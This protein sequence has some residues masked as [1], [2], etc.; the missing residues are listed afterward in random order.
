M[1]LKNKSNIAV[2]GTYEFVDSLFN[3][4]YSIEICV[5]NR[6]NSKKRYPYEILWKEAKLGNYSNLIPTE[7]TDLPYPISEND[8]FIFSQTERFFLK[9]ADRLGYLESY[10]WRKNLYLKLLSTWIYIIKDSNID[11]AIFENIPHEG[12]D[13]I[14]YNIFKEFN[15][16]CLCFYQMPIRPKE[17]Y[18]LHL[19][20]NIFDHSEIIN[21]NKKN[22]IKEA[23]YKKKFSGYLKIRKEKST[24]LNSFTRE[25]RI[26]KFQFFTLLV[27]YFKNL[28]NITEKFK[29]NKVLHF[30][31]VNLGLSDPYLPSL[32]KLISYEK[33]LLTKPDLNMKFVYL[34]LH[35]QPE[36][37]TSPLAKG[38]VDQILFINLISQVSAKLGIKVYVKEHPRAGK[39]RG[40]RTKVFYDTIKN[41]K[42]VEFIDK[43][44]NSYELIDRSFCVAA[45]TGSVGW[46]AV[47]RSKTVLMVGSRFYS[48]APNVFEISNYE[49]C[50]Q[51]MKNLDNNINNSF[52]DN[53]EN[54]LNDYLSY[55][56]PCVTE[57]FVD[58]KDSNI[59]TVTR[60]TSI[61]N[62]IALID[63]YLD[64]LFD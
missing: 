29:F 49:Q 35:Y 58:R 4:G 1:F 6:I 25:K 20:S 30:I 13:F 36:L 63:K 18:L 10:Q 3:S 15:I 28:H 61:K 50:F 43:S 55:L 41:L 24:N 33:N 47:L 48:S 51:V 31:S 9:M 2:F 44:F 59:S 40:S 57:G 22:K 38:Y 7:N 16:K 56:S 12:F 19:V 32:R 42:N 46:E 14:A 5:S 37:S 34:P 53:F 39:A 62:Q 26:K 45:I 8:L 64:I 52:D 27:H 54:K 60:S 23:N 17:T 21:L 11:V